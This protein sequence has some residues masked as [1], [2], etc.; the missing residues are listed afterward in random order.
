ML[1]LREIEERAY[2]AIMLSATD[3]L[4]DCIVDDAIPAESRIQVYRNNAQEGFT[5]SLASSYPVIKRLVGEACFRSLA[6]QY[7]IRHPSRSGDL[8]SFGLWFPSYLEI[9]YRDSEF[10]YLVDVAR[11]EWACEEVLTAGVPGSLE[12]DSLANISDSR[13]AEL[14]FSL[15][16]AHRVVSSRYPVLAIW[17]SNQADCPA[18]RIDLNSGGEQVLVVRNRGDIELHP[19]SGAFAAFVL[20]L[21]DGTPLGDAC[22]LA[23]A[24]SRQ[25]DPAAA[26]TQLARL[27]LLSAFYFA[28]CSSME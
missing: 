17:R 18:D 25:F 22:E 9:C 10:D 16:P 24:E 23:T 3:C 4:A 21:G 20:A 19:I 15:S 7:M 1:A 5:K 6:R 14:R 28:S 13:Y 26:L 11:L 2:R 8:Q 12:L 27:D